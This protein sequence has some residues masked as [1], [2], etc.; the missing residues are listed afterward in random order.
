MR[1]DDSLAYRYGFAVVFCPKHGRSV[2]YRS[3]PPSVGHTSPH[4]DR[5][6]RENQSCRCWV[7]KFK[8]KLATCWGVVCR[9]VKLLGRP[10][11]ATLTTFVPILITRNR[12]LTAVTLRKVVFAST[13][14]TE[15]CVEAATVRGKLVRVEPLVPL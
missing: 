6:C 2:Q 13:E 14:K 7:I 9:A 3:I 1:R 8:G 12:V 5:T 11:V 10:A 4:C 15:R